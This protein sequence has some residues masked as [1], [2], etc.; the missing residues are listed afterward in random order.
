MGMDK[1]IILFDIDKTLL[2]PFLSLK[3]FENEVQ[4]EFKKKIN[5]LEAYDE[6]IQKLDSSTDFYPK[7]FLEFISKKIEVSFKE[8]ERKFYNSEIWESY[9]YKDVIDTLNRV[10]SNFELG[11]FSEGFKSFQG[12]KLKMSKLNTFFKKDL[13]FISRRKLNSYF[14]EKLPKGSIIIDDNKEVVEKLRDLNRFEVFWLNRIDDQ[15]IDGVETIKS[16]KDLEKLI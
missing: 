11:I 12:R 15:K 5:I 9:V 7:D 3:D 1:K 13:L 2:N 4:N 14:L 16:L 8:L 6:Y 10:K